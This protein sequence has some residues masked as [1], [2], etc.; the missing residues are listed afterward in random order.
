MNDTANN[1]NLT[2]A[3]ETTVCGRC[4]GCGQYSYCQ[5]HGTVCFGCSGKGKVYTKRAN[6]AME[7]AR[8]LRTVK[9]EQVQVGWLLWEA[10]GPF[11][12]AGWFTV[13]AIGQDG[14]KYR[15]SPDG[16]W[17]PYTNFTTKQGTI[18]TF[19]GSDV[20][21]VENKA[22]LTEVR[23]LA[24]AYQATLTKQGTVA[25][26]GYFEAEAKREAKRAAK[27]EAARIAYEAEQAAQA[28]VRAAQEAE[29]QAQ[30]EAR[31]AELEATRIAK[32]ATTQYVG[33]VGERREFTLTVE[34]TVRF[35]SYKYGWPAA[36]LY[37]CRDEQG[38]KVVYKGTGSF[39]RSGE[40]GTVTATVK[41]HTEYRDEKQTV[42]TR[43]KVARPA[44]EEAVAEAAQ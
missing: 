19:P 30:A 21:A 3:F 34:R 26:A 32:L 9:V 18:G 38:N 2:E 42:L 24:L 20:Q 7:Y 37:I 27:A 35:E 16:E 11:S 36:T 41:D 5:M 4:G 6:A 17:L 15:T 28:V 13:T 40:T 8:T 14:S 31:A 44:E 43:P 29:A 1:T 25:P 10:G 39:L 22:R 23:A 33:T 12:K